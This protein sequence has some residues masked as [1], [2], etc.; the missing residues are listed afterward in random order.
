MFGHVGRFKASW[1]KRISALA[2]VA[3][4]AAVVGGLATT[5]SAGGA[6][7]SNPLGVYVGA[8]APSAAA[9]FGRALGQQ[10]AF[11][12]DFLNGSTWST[13][14]NG[15]PAYMSTWKGSG[16][17]MVWGLPMLPN[18]FS[19]DSNV[20]DKSGGAYGLEQGA[21]GAYNSYFLKLAQ[22]MVAGGQGSSIIRPG[23]E[24]NGNWFA[25][26]AQ[27]QAAAFV[28]YW[29][30]I[31][32]TMRS[33]PGQNFTFEWNPTAGDTGIGNLADY[34]PGNAYVDYI[35]LDLYDQ[36]WATYAGI[37][38]EWNTYLTEPYGLDW[39]A[40]FAAAQGKPITFPEWGL[41]PDSDPSAS[42]GGVASAANHK[43]GG[44]DDPTFIDDM[45]Q[46]ISQHDVFDA[47]YWDYGS[48]RLSPSSNPNSYAAFVNDFGA[49]SSFPG[50][51]PP[52]TTTTT[53]APTTTTTTGGS[54]S[55]PPVTTPPGTE[56]FS[57]VKIKPVTSQVV[58]FN[59]TQFS[60][61]VRV[62]PSK[63]AGPPGRVNWAVTSVHGTPVSCVASNAGRDPANGRTAC[64]VPPG[65]L[66][67]ANGPYTVSVRYAG[68]GSVAPSV[69]TLEQRV[70]RAGSQS[71][72]RVTPT[73]LPGHLV[74]I[75][76]IVKGS[77]AASSQPTGKVRFAVWGATGKPIPCQAGPSAL[78]SSGEA[79]CVVP[80][81]RSTHGPYYVKVTYRGDGNFAPSTSRMRSITVHSQYVSF[82]L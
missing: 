61:V 40:S 59:E 2:V 25:W 12:M 36:S 7:D 14:V 15:A 71:G 72:V 76:A 30:Q 80:D 66:A 45:A 33:V 20:A 42:G 19:P 1:S 37:S 21:S 26:A 22:E 10:P 34:Y 70:A 77:P 67:A 52:P 78:L 24:F 17:T 57:T 28:G 4:A 3:A 39:L 6:A 68:A 8:L 48:S 29:Q 35:G 69:A 54:Q 64:T 46:W 38:S 53:S 9:S 81:T 13:L 50:T 74:Q 44:G 49:G 63:A 11:A 62:L 60:A 51:P 82:L 65:Q 55:T 41:D 47:S 16:Y 27:G 5:P 75:N 73:V 43:V 58:T 79:S 31:V 32:Q 18:T 56:T 23:W